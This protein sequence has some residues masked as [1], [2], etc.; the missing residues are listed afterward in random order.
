MRDLNKLYNEDCLKGLKELPDES[1]DLVVTDCPYHIVHC[2]TSCGGGIFD[3]TRNKEVTTGKLFEN[4]DIAFSEW[5][6]EIYRVLKK[7]THCYIMINSRNIKDLQT[8][9]EKVGFEFQNLLVWNKKNATPNKYYMQC[10]EFILLLS[11]RP[12]R[13]INDMGNTNLLTV[14]NIIGNKRHPTEKPV[15]LME[16]MIRQSSNEGDVV[17]DPFAGSGS[18]LV[19]AKR[20]K[21]KFI[22]W[23][24]DP[25][26]YSVADSRLNREPQEQMLFY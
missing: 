24:I 11:K 9:S 6:P 14:P 8:A 17:L 3:V 10:L 13:N 20:A 4:N 26:F 1:I 21:R 25:K 2:G 7:G 19:A 18:T 5:L 12:A 16:Y 15:S 23:E 22:G